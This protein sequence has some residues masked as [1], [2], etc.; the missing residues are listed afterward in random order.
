[1]PELTP[2]EKL[3]DTNNDKKVSKAERKA[4]RKQ[5]PETVAGKWGLSY[6][7][8][9]QLQESDDP[10]ANQFYQWFQGKVGEYLRNPAGFNDRAFVMEFDQQPWAQ[11]YKSDAIKDMDFEARY[12]QLYAEQLDAELEVLRDQAVTFGVDIT[13]DELRDLAKQKRRF[14][15]NE[16]QLNNTLA[17]L[18]TAKGGTFK[19]ATGQVQSN[20]KQWASRN[21]LSLSDNLVNDY[22]R[23]IQA[24]DTTEFDVLQD[25]RRTYM[26]GAY[27]AWSDRIDAGYDIADIAAPYKQKM[28][29]L[30]EVD[31]NSIDFNDTLLQ[32]GLQGIDSQGKPSVVPLYEFEKQIREDPRWQ[33]TDNAYSTY[34]DVGTKLLSMFGFR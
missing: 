20:I 4:F 25:L 34:T 32:R 30:L 13:D 11:K 17:N 1:M 19:G 28:A 18:A 15:M 31:P 24:G 23:R 9:T 12:P 27:P 2:E 7:L 14:G 21:G 3:M 6:A 22:V 8:I 33:Y 16:S 5:A 29:D 26:A 10:L